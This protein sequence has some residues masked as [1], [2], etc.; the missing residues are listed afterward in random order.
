MLLQNDPDSLYLTEQE[1][2]T[3][4]GLMVYADDNLATFRVVRKLSDRRALVVKVF[5][6]PGYN[7]AVGSVKVWDTESFS[8][9]R[10]IS[11]WRTNNFLGYMSTLGPDLGY[12]LY[13]EYERGLELLDNVN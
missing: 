1:R 6:Q 4:A 8:L 3:M 12:S 13:R 10:T 5:S 11:H 9:E 2:D 7:P